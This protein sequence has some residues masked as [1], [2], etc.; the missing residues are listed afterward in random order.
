ML[1]RSRISLF[2]FMVAL[3]VMLAFISLDSLF[4]LMSI[5]ILLISGKSLRQ[6]YILNFGSDAAFEAMELRA[7]RRQTNEKDRQLNRM[8][9]F[10]LNLLFI[11]FFV[12]TYFAVDN[13]FLRIAA[14]ITVAN[15]IYDMARSFIP[16]K[17][18]ANTNNEE[19]TFKDTLAEIF[20]WFH[21]VLTI[22]VVAVAFAVKFL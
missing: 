3:P 2:A 15:W 4:V 21:N 6:L 14:G 10:L 8:M 19:W 16:H 17:A 1:I 18:T 7:L 11:I 22:A 5:L 13:V 12:F 9:V 20:M